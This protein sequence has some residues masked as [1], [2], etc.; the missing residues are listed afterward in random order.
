MTFLGANASHSLSDVVGL[1]SNY[2][3]PLED[4]AALEDSIVSMIRVDSKHMTADMKATVEKAINTLNTEIMANIDKSLTRNQ[5]E[6]KE[7]MAAF[8]PCTRNLNDKKTAIDSFM[9]KFDAKLQ[10]L[11][12][13]VNDLEDGL[14]IRSETDKKCEEVMEADC[15]KKKIDCDKVGAIEREYEKYPGDCKAKKKSG[16]IGWITWNK[17]ALENLLKR[18][19]DAMKQCSDSTDKCEK[20]TAECTTIHTMFVDRKKQCHDLQT[21]LEI[22]TCKRVAK[23][24][25]ARTSYPTCYNDA[26]AAYKKL[27]VVLRQAS[28]ERTDQWRALQR[29]TCFLGVFTKDSEDKDAEISKCREKVWTTDKYNLYLPPAPNM[30]S[31]PA[32]GHF[33]CTPEYVAKYYGTDS[34]KKWG[35]DKRCEWCAAHK[36]TPPPTPVP[37]P[38]PTPFPT[39]P[40]TE[41]PTP[42][43]TKSRGQGCWVQIFKKKKFQGP[44]TT[45]S[46]QKSQCQSDG[47]PCYRKDYVGGNFNDQMKSWKGG[48]SQCRVCFYKHSNFLDFLGGYSMQS[49][50]KS[51]NTLKQMSSLIIIDTRFEKRCP[52][53][54]NGKWT[55]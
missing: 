29:I 49:M 45:F 27:M 14:S 46:F 26:M 53:T 24:L 18:H 12:K 28:I 44:S 51:G 43:P 38:D 9:K 25:E 7:V 1:L 30:L 54:K 5:Q 32:A 19:T 10:D 36:P 55:Y 33:A 31:T 52:T 23:E 47:K 3:N 2:S 20:K 21:A 48:G 50:E 22:N 35:V 41:K 42:S 8:V 37:T 11:T 4:A 40:P 13:C 39:P 6:I 16:Y 15:E 17:V 34:F